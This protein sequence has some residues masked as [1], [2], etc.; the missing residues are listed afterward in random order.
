MLTQK[1]IIFEDNHLLIINK[2]PGVL[3]QGDETGD[4]SILDLAKAYIKEKYNKPGDVFAGL[5]H[6]LDRPVSGAIIIC[7]TSKALTRVTEMFRTDKIKK[8]YLAISDSKPKNYIGEIQSYLTKDNEK[9]IVKSSNHPLKRGGSQLAVTTYELT[10]YLEGK[11]VFKLNPVTGRPHQLRVHM[12]SMKCPIIGDKKYGSER[13]LQDK[14]IALH[15][16]SLEFIHPVSQVPIVAK[17]GYPANNI[18]DIV[19]HDWDY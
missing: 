17:A 16:R 2:R 13:V 9:N 5:P 1:D 11:G 4:L 8:M 15:C 10:M 19:R 3:S 6:R 18:W 14:S 7:R 12:S